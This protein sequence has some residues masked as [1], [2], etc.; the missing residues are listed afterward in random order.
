LTDSLF[1]GPDIAASRATVDEPAPINAPARMLMLFYVLGPLIALVVAIVRLWNRWVTPTD[2][3][4]LISL[5]YLTGFGVTVGYHRLL[6]HRSFEAHPIVRFVFLA[7]GSMAT[8]GSAV[9]WASIHIQHHAQ[10]DKDDDPHS[11]TSGLLHAHLGWLLDGFPARP[12]VYGPWLLQ[13]RM[14]MFFDRTF[15][16]WVLVGAIIPFAIGGWT[17]LLWGFGVR[18]FLVQHITWSVNSLCHTFGNRAFPTR[19]R[20]TNNWLVSLLANGEGWHNNHHAFPRSAFHGLTWWQVDTSAYLIRL[21]ERL[22]LAWN[23]HRVPLDHI[24]SKRLDAAVS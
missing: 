16:L 14:A 7:L 1:A 4:L 12:S 21:L 10:A 6:T 13:D 17:G 23:V 2:L 15:G 18:I 5:Y 19:D 3:A 8:Q 20:S 9:R 11:P 24:R 22:G